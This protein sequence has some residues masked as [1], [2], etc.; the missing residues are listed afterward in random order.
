M[1]HAWILVANRSNAR[2]FANKGSHKSLNLV[3]DFF[4]SAGRHRERDLNSDKSGRLAGSGGQ[5]RHGVGD[6]HS[7]TEHEAENFAKELAQRLHQGRTENEFTRLVLVAEPGFLGLLKGAL[8]DQTAKLLTD[9]VAK[10]LVHMS[11]SEIPD[12]VLEHV[13]L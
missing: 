4:H 13:R 1:S 9:T 6:G 7:A 2:L 8:D 5:S 11:D 3:E 10:D 12:V